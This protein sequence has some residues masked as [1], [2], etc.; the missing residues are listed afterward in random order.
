MKVTMSVSLALTYNS[1]YSFV[2]TVYMGDSSQEL[3]LRFVPS[4]LVC[5]PAASTKQIDRKLDHNI[6]FLN[7]KTVMFVGVAVYSLLGNGQ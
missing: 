1:V 5:M 2:R 3:L 4:S 6:I 7:F